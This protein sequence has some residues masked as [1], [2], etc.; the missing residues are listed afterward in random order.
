MLTLEC[1]LMG[2][3]GR[4]KARE[5][6]LRKLPNESQTAFLERTAKRSRSGKKL[7]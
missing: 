4:Q 7:K 1:V 2:K 6:N 3:R 5:K